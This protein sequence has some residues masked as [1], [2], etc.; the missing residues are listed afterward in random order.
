[1]HVAKAFIYDAE[2]N[3]LILR[4]S[5]THPNYAF[6]PDLPGGIIEPDEDI[7]TGLVREVEEEA[8]FTIDSSAFQVAFAD[9]QVGKYTRHLYT[10]TLDQ[11]KPDVVISWEHDQYEWLTPAEILQKPTDPDTDS[12]YTQAIEWLTWDAN[13]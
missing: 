10:A 2:G 9:K 12:Y 4:R 11:V 1:M 3:I 6:Q 7:L 13:G 8:G 5:S